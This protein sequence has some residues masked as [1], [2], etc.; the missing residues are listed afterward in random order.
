[1]KIFKTLIVGGLT[2][3]ALA[4]AAAPAQGEV[5]VGFRDVP[6][7]SRGFAFRRAGEER[8]RFRRRGAERRARPRA[9]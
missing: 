6:V 4:P 1:M 2:A 3:A 5:K 7:R 9:L 8:C